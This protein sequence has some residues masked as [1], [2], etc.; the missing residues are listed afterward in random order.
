MA[1]PSRNRLYGPVRGL[2]RERAAGPFRDIR[3]GLLEFAGQLKKVQTDF[4]VLVL[5]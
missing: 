4:L 2:E 5:Q 3:A 1:A